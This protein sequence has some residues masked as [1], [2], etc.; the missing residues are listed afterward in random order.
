MQD[1]YSA[2]FIF[3]KKEYDDEFYTL[4]NMI[5]EIAKKTAGYLGD[6]SYVHPESGQLINIYYWEGK[7]GLD[8]LIHNDTHKEAKQKHAKWLSGYQVVIAKI[9]A[10]YNDGKIEHPL[11]DKL[12]KKA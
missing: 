1:I 12:I 8:A 4:D 5:A 9:E 6:E 3:Q 10:A 7:E 2:T 11:K